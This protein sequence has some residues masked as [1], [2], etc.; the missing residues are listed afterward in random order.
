MS[1]VSKILLAPGIISA[2]EVYD[3]P[4]GIYVYGIAKNPR[5]EGG[6]EGQYVCY[7][8]QKVDMRVIYPY[9]E[10]KFIQ[11][12]TPD[13]SGGKGKTYI[14]IPMGFGT[15]WIRPNMKCDYDLYIDGNKYVTF[16]CVTDETRTWEGTGGVRLAYY[17]L[18]KDGVGEP[19]GRMLL[20]LPPGFK[21][22]ESYLALKV[23]PAK[24]SEGNA[25][26]MLHVGARYA[27]ND[28]G[29]WIKQRNWK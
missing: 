8:T 28:L 18:F 5:L 25:W 29:E 10:G 3:D 1:L 20:E 26:F 24:G 2:G 21:R 27:G 14:D 13:F 16:G 6:R 17:A 22:E 4:E 15:G 7:S 19:H 11:W 23:T 9:E 12:E